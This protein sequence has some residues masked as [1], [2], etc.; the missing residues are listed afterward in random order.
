MGKQISIFVENKPGK[1]S[2]I[3]EVLGKAKINLKAMTIADS[4]SFGV[5]KIMTDNN[6]KAY[7]VL[8]ENNFLVSLQEVVVVEIPDKVGSFH[9][10]AKI[11]EKNRVNIEDAYGFITTEGVK[12][13][14]ILKV[15]DVKTVEKI[16]KE[17]GYK[18]IDF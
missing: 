4:G 17:K 11:L 2:K 15:K 5:I 3:T 16:L 9:K 12:A 8:K 10:V 13:V 1:I 14:L 7:D 18:I 6:Q